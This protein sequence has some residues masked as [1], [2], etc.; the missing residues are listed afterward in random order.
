M[1]VPV[2][3]A[4]GSSRSGGLR[5]DGQGCLPLSHDRRFVRIHYYVRTF[6]PHRSG[7]V[8][9]VL[10][11]HGDAVEVGY[12]L[13]L[14]G[15][16]QERCV[17]QKRE[18]AEFRGILEE[19]RGTEYEALLVRGMRLRT[20]MHDLQPGSPLLEVLRR[21]AERLKLRLDM[22]HRAAGLRGRWSLAAQGERGEG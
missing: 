5:S 10:R 15:D 11:D 9:M 17:F 20:M 12:G 14:N 19:D 22:L 21:R 4:G 13:V 8:G 18:V 16:A 1:G 2:R 7:Q 6:A 3:A